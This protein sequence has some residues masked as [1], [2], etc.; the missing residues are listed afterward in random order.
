MVRP[1]P[2]GVMTHGAHRP[3]TMGNLPAIVSEPPV[4]PATMSVP[5]SGL[6]PP[7]QEQTAVMAEGG[8]TSSEKWYVESL[9][10]HT[11][12]SPPISGISMG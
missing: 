4:P 12:L 9:H 6:F 1:P 7:A 5:V 10:S 8:A 2:A 3:S 11:V